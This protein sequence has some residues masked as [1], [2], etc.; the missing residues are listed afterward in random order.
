MNQGALRRAHKLVPTA[1][2]AAAWRKDRAQTLTLLPIG[3][4]N[5]L[6]TN[7]H[8]SEL[9]KMKAWKRK[10]HPDAADFSTMPHPIDSSIPFI[11]AVAGKRTGCDGQ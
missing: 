8:N 11:G 6:T 4:K 1:H 10:A 2:T 7:Q 3:L 9:P 5:D